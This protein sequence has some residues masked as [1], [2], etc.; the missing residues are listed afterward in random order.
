MLRHLGW[1]EAA[2]LIEQGIQGSLADKIVTYDLARQM[3]GAKLTSCSGF[4]QS[5]VQHMSTLSR[6]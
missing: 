1:D 2:D 4:G 5:I 3:V 6:P